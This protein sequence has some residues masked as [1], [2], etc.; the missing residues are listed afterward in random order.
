MKSK[1]YTKTGDTG[2]TSLIGGK[3]VKKCDLKVEA[4]GTIDEL[5][6]ILGV[7]RSYPTDEI[8][9]ESIIRIQKEL[10]TIG[11]CLASINPIY[12][13][14]NDS[15]IYFLESEIDRIT[16]KLPPIK[17]FVIP[18]GNIISAQC[19]L[20]RTICR[21][22]ERK[23]CEIS[24]KNPI[25]KEILMYINRLSDYL[26]VLARHFSKYFEENEILFVPEFHK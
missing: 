1:I 25:E 16:D 6:A 7:L 10:F 15:E 14:L 13:E 2:L 11:S 21:R 3:R 23:M 20:A 9:Q 12:N 17:N 18:G 26:F 22:A 5:I 24:S 19:N 4:Y 8:S